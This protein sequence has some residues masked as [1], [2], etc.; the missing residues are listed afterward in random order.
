MPVVTLTAAFVRSA[1]C[2]PN[3]KKVDYYS[4]AISGFILEV[5]SSGHKTW[6]QRYRDPF[7]RLKAHRI[8]SAQSVS[9]EKAKKAALQIKAKVSM[10]EDPVEQRKMIREM[11]TLGEIVRD[12]YMPHI[13]TKKRRP[14]FDEG[15]L[16]LHILP[17]FGRDKLAEITPE[18]IEAWHKAKHEN[19]LSPAYANAMVGVLKHVFNL[20]KR[21]DIA[22]AEKNPAQYVP[23]L[24][25]DNIKEVF[26]NAEQTERLIQAVKASNNTQLQY[27]VPLLLL[28]GARKRELLD[29]RWEDMDIKRRV[30]RIPMSKSGK[31]R[32]VPLSQTAVQLLETVPRFE[33][34]P[35]VVPNP[36]TKQ[37]FRSIWG[38]WKVAR[39]QAGLPDCRVHDL[40]HSAASNAIAAGTSIWVV[41]RWLGHSK[42]TTTQRYAHVADKTLLD[43][44]DAAAK[45]TGIVVLRDEP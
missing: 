31:P 8:G 4:D 25:V 21:W 29:A 34:C 18:R 35:Y 11:P 24:V 2:T 37:P 36:Q 19:G 6:Y 20:A 39:E 5:R 15:I 28:T 33:G 26:L 42:V 40:R 17:E 32:T 23:M 12:R 10:G 44:V 22:G 41:S 3:K 43:A 38:S 27:I 30:W 45:E 9:F 16:R 14:D 1:T 7:G 13:K